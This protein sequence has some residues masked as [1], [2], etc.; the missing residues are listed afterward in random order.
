MAKY[1]KVKL[2]DRI[3]PGV[4]AELAAEL[5]PLLAPY[6]AHQWWP[7][8]EEADTATEVLVDLFHEMG[9]VPS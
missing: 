3:P 4:Q 2:A 6:F 8:L 5:R 1:K 7:S 9:V